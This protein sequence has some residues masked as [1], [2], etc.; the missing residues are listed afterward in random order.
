QR[1][2]HHANIDNKIYQEKVIDLIRHR[3]GIVVHSHQLNELN[4]ILNDA[5]VKFSISP[6]DYLQLLAKNSE[7]TPVLDDLMAK[8]TVGE[9]Y[10]F[11]DKKQ[12]KLLEDVIL[13]DLITKKRALND[14][15]LRIWSAGCASGE[16][17]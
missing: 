15:N 1:N 6:E 2:F 4:K 9:T 13:P 16:E 14:L 7:S 10:F 3:F 5:F 8:I 17:I 11:R 12:V